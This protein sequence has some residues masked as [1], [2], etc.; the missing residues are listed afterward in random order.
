ML[1]SIKE[2]AGKLAVG[3]DSVGRLID[4]GELEAVEFPK[5]GGR[6]K[7]RKRM[8]EDDEIERFK[9]RR[10]SRRKLRFLM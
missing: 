3:R 7:N 5:M 6:G 1:L 8:I 10:K 9:E 4:R 2:A